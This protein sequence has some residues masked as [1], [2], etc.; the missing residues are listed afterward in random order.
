MVLHVNPFAK[1]PQKG[2]T[3]KGQCA[4]ANPGPFTLEFDI[5]PFRA[6]PAYMPTIHLW[7]ARSTPTCPPRNAQSGPRVAKV[8]DSL[9]GVASARA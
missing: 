9:A 3:P 7:N 5:L 6:I 1:S 4:C 2:H 8:P